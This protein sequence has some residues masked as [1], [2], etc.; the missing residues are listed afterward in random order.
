MRIF[1]EYCAFNRIYKLDGAL[2]VGKHKV[3]D[4]RQRLSESMA[5]HISLLGLSYDAVSPV[6]NTGGLYTH[7]ISEL[8]GM[9][10]YKIF[11]KDTVER[12]LGGDALE[13]EGYY[14]KHLKYIY[15]DV[16]IDKKI[17]FIDEA[18]LSGLTVELIA[19]ACKANGIAN[20]SFAFMSPV[21]HLSCPFGHISNTS[22]VFSY[23]NDGTYSDQIE[24]FRKKV[25]AQEIIFL[26]YSSFATR[27]GGDSVCKLCFHDCG[28]EDTY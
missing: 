6:P 15:S 20:Y 9:P 1:D 23:L 5:Q 26:P 24:V 4:V 25:G 22:R 2:N 21:N 13:R 28:S 12:T 8:L 14:Q 17:L 16:D 19:K 11:E 10:E 18:L 7:S 3:E 27:V